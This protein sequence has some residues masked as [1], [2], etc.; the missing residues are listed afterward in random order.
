[1]TPDPQ[2][3][4]GIVID[5]SNESD[6]AFV[7]TVFG[8]SEEEVRQAFQWVGADLAAVEKYL[9]LHRVGRLQH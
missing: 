2:P 8:V 9:A 5:P 7:A 1:M 3:S 6:T 4:S